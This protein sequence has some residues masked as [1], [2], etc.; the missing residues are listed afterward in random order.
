M[1]IKY[2][3]RAAEIF[4]AEDKLEPGLYIGTVRGFSRTV[5]GILE[6]LMGGSAIK[7]LYFFERPTVLHKPTT[8]SVRVHKLDPNNVELQVKG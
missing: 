4:T 1:N 3:P 6:V 2:D 5:F 7:Y 8:E